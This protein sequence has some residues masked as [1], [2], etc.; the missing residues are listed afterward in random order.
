MAKTLIISGQTYTNV[1]GF[2]ATDSNDTVQT[3]IQP[4]GSTTI[5]SNGTTDVTSQLERETR[6]DKNNNPVVSY[7]YKLNNITANH[8]INVT[9]GDATIQLYVKE[10]DTWRMYSKVYKKINGSWV[11]QSDIASVFSTSANYVK[12]N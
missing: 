4:E 3:Y 1:A 9:A 11:E 5:T 8:T 12:G 6:V 2:K 10:N 7:K